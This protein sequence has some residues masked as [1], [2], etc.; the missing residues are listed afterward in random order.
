[1][2]FVVQVDF[3]KNIVIVTLA[4]IAIAMILL[5][6]LLVNFGYNYVDAQK[7]PPR[8]QDGDGRPNNID[9]CPR[10]SNPDQRDSDGDGAGD[11]CDSTLYHNQQH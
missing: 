3:K 7:K 5:A 8:D 10:I 11:V 4:I 9:N 6:S 1:M 2:Q